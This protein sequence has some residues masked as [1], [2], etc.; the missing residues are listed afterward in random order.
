MSEE[1]MIPQK[2]VFEVHYIIQNSSLG[3][4]PFEERKEAIHHLTKKYSKYVIKN[5]YL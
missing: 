2:P 1:K 3:F 4:S 5:E